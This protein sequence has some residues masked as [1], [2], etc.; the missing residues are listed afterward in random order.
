MTDTF[1]RDSRIEELREQR[2]ELR[3]DGDDLEYEEEE[4]LERLIAEKKKESREYDK[5]RAAEHKT[6]LAKAL[7][8]FTNADVVWCCPPYGEYPAVY[9]VGKEVLVAII[10]NGDGDS[11]RFYQA[12]RPAMETVKQDDCP[13]MFNAINDD[14]PPRMVYENAIVVSETTAIDTADRM[15]AAGQAADHAAA[16][17]TFADYI[18]RKAPNTVD[19]Q[20]FDLAVFAEYLKAVGVPVAPERLQTALEAWRGM[21][22]GLVQGFV[23]WQLQQGH[24][25]A[26]INR[27]LST[28]KTYAKL[29]TQAGSISAQDLALIKT[30][31]G[32]GG[33]EAKRVDDK[34][35]E[36]QQKT[37]QGH[38][39]AE[40]VS[41]TDDQADALKVQPLD[42]PQ[43]RRD[44]VLMAL[45]LD[46]GLRAGEVAALTVSDVDLKAGQL[47]FYRPKVDKTQ[48][49]KLSVDALKALR[50]YFDNGDAPALGQLLR[51]S[52]KGGKLDQVGMSETSITER[53]RTL[54][55]ALDIDGLSAHDCRHYWATYWG[56]R[57]ERLPK[58]VFSL[59]EAGGWNS[60][61]MPRRY[62][63]SAKISNEG[64]A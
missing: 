53:V 33:K 5:R 17:N 11:D 15:R 10:G 55:K 22:W 27:R 56:N 1:D 42:T 34:R 49:N 39:K 64:M 30:V 60:L 14:V 46:H 13:D 40:H 61:A 9:S 4:E 63:E 62:V 8:E 59:Q 25:T 35:Q 50:A 32:Y 23:E 7:E 45:L 54:G 3:K 26:S 19:A 20:R 31:A 16:K 6:A 24:A 2:K 29:A 37:R 12:P 18:S 44:A 58:G 47:R 48:N 43:G 28:V 36:N 51:G 52:R 38:K 21:T 41:L 57:V